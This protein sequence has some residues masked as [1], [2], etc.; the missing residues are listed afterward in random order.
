MTVPQPFQNQG[1]QPGVGTVDSAIPGNLVIFCCSAG[2]LLSGYQVREAFNLMKFIRTVLGLFLLCACAIE[3]S[4]RSALPADVPINPDAGRGNWLIVTLQLGSGQKLPMIVDTGAGATVLDKSLTT[5]LG[6][7][8][9]A[10]VLCH[11]GKSITNGVYPAPKLFLGGTPLLLT[12][13]AI[14]CGDLDLPRGTGRKFMGILGM[15]VLENYCLQLDFAA[16]KMRFLDD[17]HADKST[18]GRPFP[19]VHLTDDDARPAVAENL[20]GRP[21]PHSIIDSGYLGDGWFRSNYFQT[22][23]NDAV[24]PTNGESRRPYGRFGGKTYPLF[25]LCAENVESDGIGIN[26]LARHLV[27]LDFPN[28]TMYLQRQSI[29]L[30]PGPKLAEYQPIPDREP[31]VTAHL[32]AVLQARMDGSAQ[33]DDYTA[34]AWKRLQS[35]QKDLQTFKKY[36]GDIVSLTLVEHKSMLGWRRSYRYR[37]EFTRATVLAHFVFHGRNKLASGQMTTVEWKEPVD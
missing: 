14:I 32:R 27:T 18:W 9:G 21:G 20:L 29:G 13:D 35:K 26:F 8:L 4:A 7:C 30:R 33:A 25:S 2:A 36:V 28:H 34:S 3:S 6:K 16:G 37:I 11:W 24:A 5:K 23:T 19:I 22:W 15:D 17:Q 31:E 10:A 12:G 1:S